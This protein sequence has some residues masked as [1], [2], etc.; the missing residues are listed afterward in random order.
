VTTAVATVGAITTNVISAATIEASTF[1]LDGVNVHR[2]DVVILRLLIPAR[3][4]KVFDDDVP[5]TI[6]VLSKL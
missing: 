5:Q 6:I 1:L 3:C 4:C 2:L